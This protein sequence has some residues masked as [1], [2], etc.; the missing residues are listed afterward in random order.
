MTIIKQDSANGLNIY[1]NQ[2]NPDFLVEQKLTLCKF[3]IFIVNI[4]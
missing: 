2:L 3:L 1:K 4:N